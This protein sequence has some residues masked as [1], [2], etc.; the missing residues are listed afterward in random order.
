MWQYF[1]IVTCSATKTRVWIG[2]SIYWILVV[3]TI[4]SYTQKITVTI[5][6]ETTHAKPSNSS[7][8]NTGV[9]L[10]LRNSTEVNSRSRILLY[11]LDTDHAQ[12]TKF[13]RCEAQTTLITS[14]V[15]AISPAHWRTDCCIAIQVTIYCDMTPESRNSGVG[16]RRPLLE[17]GSVIIFPRQPI[18]T[19][20]TK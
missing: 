6:H 7:S 17:N 12:K 20:Y 5:A 4:S 3:T 2:E 1:N 18:L 10:E 11:S 19:R 13:Y 15:L 9:P 16:A 8:D 14:H